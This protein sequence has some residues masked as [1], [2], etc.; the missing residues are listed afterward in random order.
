MC[1]LIFNV[2]DKPKEVYSENGKYAA[3]MTALKDLPDDKCVTLT[4]DSKKAALIRGSINAIQ[5][6]WGF[7]VK[8]NY[9]RKNGTLYLSRVGKSPIPAQQEQR[10]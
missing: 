4:V 10:R 1:E 2:V 5:K 9:D 3:I 6:K 7:K 8:V